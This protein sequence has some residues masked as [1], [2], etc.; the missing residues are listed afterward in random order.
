[1]SQR[2]VGKGL[3]PG[4]AVD[5]VISWNKAESSKKWA[6]PGAL[7]CT[8]GRVQVRGVGPAG[9]GQGQAAQDPPVALPAVALVRQLRGQ[10]VE[11]VTA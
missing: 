9:W 8:P 7:F 5:D 11:A 6:R 2:A 4:V 10:V 3:G 1:M